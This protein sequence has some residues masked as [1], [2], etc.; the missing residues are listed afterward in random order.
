VKKN[1]LFYFKHYNLAIYV[2]KYFEKNYINYF[3]ILGYDP[4]V[5]LRKKFGK[6]IYAIFSRS[7]SFGV[8]FS[9]T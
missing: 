7:G 6:S 2:D 5:D 9:K 3:N 1:S 4:I 8:F